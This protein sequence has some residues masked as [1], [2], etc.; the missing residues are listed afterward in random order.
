MLKAEG[1]RSDLVSAI[2]SS[3]FLHHQPVSRP[4]GPSLLPEHIS[5]PVPVTVKH[6][7]PRLAWPF[8]TC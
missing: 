1:D 4:T 7:E 6:E 2:S 8:A 3:L 5:S